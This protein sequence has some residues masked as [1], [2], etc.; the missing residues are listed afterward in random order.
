[1]PWEPQD[2]AC[3]PATISTKDM[4]QKQDKKEYCTCGV[5]EMSTEFAKKVAIVKPVQSLPQILPTTGKNFIFKPIDTEEIQ[6][7]D[8]EL[9]SLSCDEVLTISSDQYLEE[10]M[11]KLKSEVA[12][13]SSKQQW[14]TELY[15]RVLCKNCLTGYPIKNC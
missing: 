5:G 6:D 4:F 8:D 13:K 7:S 12:K 15:T 10:C 9:P 1:M 3:K 11:L 2:F 14:K